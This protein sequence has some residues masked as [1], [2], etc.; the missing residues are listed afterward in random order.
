MRFQIIDIIE[1]E[2]KKQK[3]IEN[4]KEKDNKKENDTCHIINFTFI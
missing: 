4:K 3:E 1:N 2:E